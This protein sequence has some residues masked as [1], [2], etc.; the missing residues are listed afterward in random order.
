MSQTTFPVQV[1]ANGTYGPFGLSQ[2]KTPTFQAAFAMTNGYTAGTT[3]GSA[4]IQIDNSNDG[5]AADPGGSICTLSPTSAA[6]DSVLTAGN[7]SSC[8][9]TVTNYVAP[10]PGSGVITITAAGG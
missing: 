1:S 8:Y 3:G 9:I 4:T 6:P 2:F 10:S 5:V 7:Y